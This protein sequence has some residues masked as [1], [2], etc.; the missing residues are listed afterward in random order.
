MPKILI[1]AMPRGIG[2]KGKVIKILP[3]GKVLYQSDIE[4]RKRYLA[5]RKLERQAEQKKKAKEKKKKF[6]VKKD[7][8]VYHSDIK[9]RGKF[10]AKRTEKRVVKQ[11]QVKQETAKKEAVRESR[12]ATEVS[13]LGQRYAET[14]GEKEPR[15]PLIDK[16]L[17]K[18]KKP[19]TETEKR[20]LSFVQDW[21]SKEVYAY[22]VR[23]G[24]TRGMAMDDFMD[25]LENNKYTMY[26]NRLGFH[27]IRKGLGE[28]IPM[29][30]PF[31]RKGLLQKIKEKLH[32]APSTTNPSVNR[33]QKVMKESASNQ[34]EMTKDWRQGIFESKYKN[35][36][37]EKASRAYLLG[38]YAGRIKRSKKMMKTQGDRLAR[39]LQEARNRGISI[40]K[41][42]D[43]NFDLTKGIKDL[44]LLPSPTNPSVRRHQKPGEE[45]APVKKPAKVE[46]KKA[47]YSGKLEKAAKKFKSM[48]YSNFVE[49]DC[50]KEGDSLIA[51]KQGK[52]TGYN[53]FSYDVAGQAYI[54]DLT[55]SD[56]FNLMY[57]NYTA[58]SKHGKQ[59]LNELKSAGLTPDYDIGL[60]ASAVQ[61]PDSW[62]EKDPVDLSEESVVK[63]NP[64]NGKKERYR[65]G[66][67]AE[68]AIVFRCKDKKEAEKVNAFLNKR[69]VRTTEEY[70]YS[71]KDSWW[72]PDIRSSSSEH[73]D[74]LEERV[75]NIKVLKKQG[76]ITLSKKEIKKEGYTSNKVYVNKHLAKYINKAISRMV[77]LVKSLKGILGE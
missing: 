33:W 24:A 13:K 23:M 47:E 35:R 7:K 43:N 12:M 69:T 27:I 26:K 31:L 56:K 52:R 65:I 71:I 50:E 32:L 4:A 1:K 75:A 59:L 11:D 16:Y 68:Y 17:S 15:K 67:T 53:V 42:F 44:P 62:G 72:A 30:L 36:P 19:T 3:S 66:K 73:Y 28:D 60:K 61:W 55:A 9:A 74:E 64:E 70:K 18:V 22:K 38:F 25:L 34:N 76:V 10:V 48:T 49:K 51:L 63:M 54:D 39:L 21:P 57:H 29:Y 46:P 45:P 8:K 77:Y 6:V 14:L 37:K 20:V 5:K 58:N 40:A 41:S 2:R